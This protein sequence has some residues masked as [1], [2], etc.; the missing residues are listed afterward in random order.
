MRLARL[1]PLFVVLLLVSC[2][3]AQAEG[4]VDLGH[5]NL[6]RAPAKVDPLLRML[7][8]RNDLALREAGQPLNLAPFADLVGVYASDGSLL[9]GPRLAGK[10][11]VEGA[12]ADRVEVLITTEGSPEELKKAGAQVGTVAG[13]IVTARLTLGQLER[14]AAL[15]NVTYVAA[16]HRVQLFGT[17]APGL[18]ADSF[19]HPNLDVSMPET[20]ADACH[21]LGTAGAG[22]VVGVADT[23]LDLT[24]PDF[25]D[26]IVC[27]AY[28]TRDPLDTYGHGTHVTGIA[29][30]DGSS[31]AAG[32]IG[33]APEADI[34][35]AKVVLTD[36]GIIDGVSFIFSQAAALGEP[37]VVNL[38]LGNQFGPHDGSSSFE[39]SLE[40]LLGPGKIV[41]ASAGNDGDTAIHA[42]GD[43]PAG[44]C[45]DITTD[46]NSADASS[47]FDYWYDG[48]ADV[49]LTVLTPNGHS[50]GPVCA[51]DALDYQMDPAGVTPD[52]C[53]YMDNASMGPAPN[54]DNE[55]VTYVDGQY[56]GCPN[57]V[58]AGTWTYRFCA[59]G[60]A[61]IDGWS[62][63]WDEVQEFDPPY[64]NTDMTVGMPATAE[65]VIAVGSYVTKICWESLDGTWCHQDFFPGEVITIGDISPYSSKGPTRDGRSKPDISA[66]GTW[67]ASALSTA[68]SWYD[69]PELITPDGVHLMLLGTSMS[70]P[71]VTGA[72]AL[73][74]EQDPSLT[75]ADVKALLQSN[76]LADAFT[77]T[78]SNLTW[79]AGKLRVPG[80]GAP[81]LDKDGFD[82]D[83][84]TYVGT[85]P[86]DACPDVTGTSGLCPGPSCDGDDAWPLDNNID[87]WS[88]VLDVLQYKGHL[89]I[90]APDP[91][92]VQRLDI[93]ADECV[94]VLDV[95]LYKGHLEVQCTNP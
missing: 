62:N 65:D 14:I 48:A 57:D 45:I 10:E 87:T 89:Q 33:M 30:G 34:C 32:Y 2:F 41:V 23:G 27:Y 3:S 44:G 19:S 90:C 22:A 25:H 50:V 15:P 18:S 26:R 39:Q 78:T 5:A 51:G 43:V 80:C 55:L 64:G 68:S 46:A 69:Y 60:G 47:V 56:Y 86:F 28:P 74:L 52:G 38:S 67:I 66:P 17:E 24:H 70:A 42:G 12:S 16:S 9:E 6:E 91:N 83:V 59:E 4:P 49:C 11:S 61:H 58:A 37:A 88:N 94:N 93:N 79:G 72:V 13:N 81:D 92:Y 54:G 7:L 82:D 20:G 36:A 29:A 21:A 40:S 84:E 75:P 53:V 1:L 73:L 31:S 8:T 71:H 95:L 85:D 76:A 35:A 77:G 63:T